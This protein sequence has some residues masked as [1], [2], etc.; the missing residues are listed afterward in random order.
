MDVCVSVLAMCK[1][2]LL[3][4]TLSHKWKRMDGWVGGWIGGWIGGWMG[5]WMDA[6]MDG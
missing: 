4:V 6:W 2:T 1:C 5:V 3:F